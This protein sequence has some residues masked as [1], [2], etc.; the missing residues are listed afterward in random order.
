VNLD[1]P[2]EVAAPTH[3]PRML[4]IN[5]TADDGFALQQLAVAMGQ[6][7]PAVV[8]ELIRRAMPRQNGHVGYKNTCTSCG[9][10]YASVR[11]AVPGRRNYCPDCRATG[12][13]AADRARDYRERKAQERAK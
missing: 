7:I 1:D 10:E 8:H 2:I 13:P 6:P 9:K 12:E 3:V 11:R 4:M 5:I